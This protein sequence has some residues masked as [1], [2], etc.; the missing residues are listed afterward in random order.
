MHTFFTHIPIF[1]QSR[2]FRVACIGGIGVIIQTAIFETLGIWLALVSASTAAVIGGEVAIVCN[3]ALNNRFSFGDRGH[4]ALGWRL[5]RFHMVVAGSLFIQW[6][7]V[8]T[9]E[10][11][12]H[13]L[14]IIHGAYAAGILVG[15][16][17]NYIGYH[18]FVWRKH[19][20]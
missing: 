12:T 6:L 16:M 7:F 8:F 19:E 10:H 14:L 2:I 3:F 1:I 13:D 20:L 4:G 5:L 17:S 11:A 9:A 18:L 15:F